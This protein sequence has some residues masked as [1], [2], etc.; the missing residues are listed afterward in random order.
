MT[1]EITHYNNLY[2]IKGTLNKLNLQKFNE[3]FA[4]IFEKSNN[5]TINI[6]RVIS[7]DRAGV[8]ALAKLHNEALNK[9]KRLAIV[10]LGCKELYE[11]F[12]A[13]ET[14]A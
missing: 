4:G 2:Q 6:E 1:L 8:T 11:H 5:I 12:K 9:G 3:T 14:A 10:G 7:I 13:E